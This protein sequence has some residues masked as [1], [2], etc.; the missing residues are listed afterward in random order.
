MDKLVKYLIDYAEDL[1]GNPIRPSEEVLQR[2][3]AALFIWRKMGMSHD[4]MK[5]KDPMNG[6]GWKTLAPAAHMYALSSE[7][8]EK[9]KKH[10][11]RF[12]IEL[13]EAIGGDLGDSLWYI[14]KSSKDTGTEWNLY[15]DCDDFGSVAEIK[16]EIEYATNVEDALAN[17]IFHMQN[18]FISMTE[19]ATSIV[20][21]FGCSES[22]V[23]QNARMVTLL[24]ES[25][26]SEFTEKVILPYANGESTSRIEMIF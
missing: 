4:I 7:E 16:E 17:F 15:K 11:N 20:F 10:L 13:K 1:I 5:Q 19:L 22:S 26:T 18:D 9:I 6:E 2:D 25:E 8:L 24:G 3:D 14:V 21:P 23:W 12:Y